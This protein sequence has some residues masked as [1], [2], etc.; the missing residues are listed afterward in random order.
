[1]AKQTSTSTPKF[2]STPKPVAATPVRKTVMP[3]PAP[4]SAAAPTT[5]AAPVKP[6][7]THDLIARRAYE[8]ATSGHGGS[9]FDNWLRAERELRQ[10]LGA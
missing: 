4:A 7:L 9:E 5:S 6:T 10:E 8:I 1:M 3:R 2:S